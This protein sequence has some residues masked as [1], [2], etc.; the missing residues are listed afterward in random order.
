M[1]KT[2]DLAS[3]QDPD[4]IGQMELDFDRYMQGIESGDVVELEQEDD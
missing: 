2:K 1:M 3:Q 4:D